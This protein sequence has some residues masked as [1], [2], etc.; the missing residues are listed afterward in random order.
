MIEIVPFGDC[1]LLVKLGDDISET[2]HLKVKQVYL[3]L[4]KNKNE[5]ILSITPAYNSITVIY[6]NSSFSK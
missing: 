5:N 1:A 6:H 3:S 4:K 2:T